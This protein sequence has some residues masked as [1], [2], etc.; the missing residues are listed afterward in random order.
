M[1]RKMGEDE[2]R[3]ANYR[4]SRAASDLATR[5]R[6]SGLGSG[7]LRASNGGGGNDGSSHKLTLCTLFQQPVSEVFQQVT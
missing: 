1:A 5:V 2:M 3:R 4:K 7:Q 6:L